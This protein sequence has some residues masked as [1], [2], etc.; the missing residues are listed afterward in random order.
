MRL[1]SHSSPTADKGTPILQHTYTHTHLHVVVCVF[2]YDCGL[3]FPHHAPYTT[4]SGT[5]ENSRQA[6]GLNQSKRQPSDQPTDC[7]VARRTDHLSIVKRNHA[8]SP[9]T[10]MPTQDVHTHI[11]IYYTNN[12]FLRLVSV[13]VCVCSYV[14]LAI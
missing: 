4:V 2:P 7:Q 6:K 13:Y 8:E 11:H 14:L 3:S 9:Y 5:S 1:L 12:C 10:H